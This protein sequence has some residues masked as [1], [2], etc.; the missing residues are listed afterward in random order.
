MSCKRLSLLFVAFLLAGCSRVFYQPGSSD[1]YSRYVSYWH[2]RGEIRRTPTDLIMSADAVFLSCPL[3]M[4]MV[5]LIAQRKGWRSIE[6]EFKKEEEYAECQAYYDFVLAVYTKDSSWN[7]LDSPDSMWKVI[8]VADGIR[9]YPE[10]IVRVKPKAD[11]VAVF[12]PFIKPWMK[13][14]RV[15]FGRA[16]IRN[17]KSLKLII[18][19]LMGRVTLSWD[20]R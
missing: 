10:S 12:Y 16:G 3:R 7:D 20:L 8:L 4:R 2:R 11:E 17:A 9:R 13:V 19:S 15:R 6:T 1:F 5:D 14:Y 18:T